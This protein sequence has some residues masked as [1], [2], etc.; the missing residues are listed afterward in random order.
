[1]TTTHIALIVIWILVIYTIVIYNK[2]VTLRNNRENSF[3]DIDV[4]LQM[5]ADLIP[6]LL[7]TVKW[8]M[9]HERETLEKVTEARTKFLNS[10]TVDEKVESGNMLEW[11]LKSLF[12]VSEAYPDLKA[13]ENFLQMQNEMSD[14][15]NKLAAARRY[16]NNS[17]KELNTYVE[18]FPQN[19]IAWMFSFKKK[20]YF[21][22]EDRE[23]LNKAPEISFN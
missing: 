16:F 18:I 5:R 22:V 17:T 11:A 9:K 14:I 3:A 6:Q 13:N 10:N 15:E 2:L 21:E 23:T 8:Y 20:E 12:A 7:E 19:I 4:Q 1:M